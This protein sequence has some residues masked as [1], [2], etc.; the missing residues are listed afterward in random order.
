M[1]SV[2]RQSLNTSDFRPIVPTPNVSFY[3][4]ISKYL[5]D[6]FLHTLFLVLPIARHK[7]LA[8]RAHN[9]LLS[10]NAEPFYL[11]VGTTHVQT[12]MT[13][14]SADNASLEL[15]AHAA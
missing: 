15:V 12:G 9:V 4:V 8:N 5:Q 11:L 13:A 3:Q 1:S 14:L 6:H 7:S 10:H 2:S